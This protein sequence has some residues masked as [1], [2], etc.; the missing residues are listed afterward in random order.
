VA[1]DATAVPR[2]DA[3][4]SRQAGR[5]A[6]MVARPTKRAGMECSCFASGDQL[7]CVA[8]KATDMPATACPREGTRADDAHL[9]G[10]RGLLISA[11]VSAAQ[12]RWFGSTPHAKPLLAICDAETPTGVTLSKHT[13]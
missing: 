2:D 6:W 10:R 5:D 9:S 4:R 3:S 8:A 12:R 1:E 13:S 11:A 7:I